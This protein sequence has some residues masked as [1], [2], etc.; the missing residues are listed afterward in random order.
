MEGVGAAAGVGSASTDD[1]SVS[2]DPYSRST[3]PIDQKAAKTVGYVWRVSVYGADGDYKCLEREGGSLSQNKLDEMRVVPEDTRGS[4]RP[5]PIVPWMW[6]HFTLELGSLS[7][8]DTVVISSSVLGDSSPSSA[9]SRCTVQIRDC[10]LFANAQELSIVGQNSSICR[11]GIFIP[12]EGHAL[13]TAV[14]FAVHN[15]SRVLF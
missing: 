14:S 6:R 8:N 11:G 5:N 12:V 2:F 7:A 3:V 10:K 4:K 1:S 13:S 15:D 9:A